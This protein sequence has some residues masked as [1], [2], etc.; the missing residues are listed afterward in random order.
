MERMEVLDQAL[1][2]AHTLEPVKR[3]EVQALHAE[4]ADAAR[5]GR[6]ELFKTSDRDDRAAR[7]PHWPG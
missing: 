2:A 5:R 6:F 3:E 4:T 1:D 7:N